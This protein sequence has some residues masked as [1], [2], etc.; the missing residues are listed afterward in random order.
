M[1]LNPPRPGFMSDMTED[2]R[3]IMKINRL[4]NFDKK[5]VF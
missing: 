5:D 2:E 1:K 4:L 3:I